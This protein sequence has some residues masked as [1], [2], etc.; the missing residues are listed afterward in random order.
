[1]GRQWIPLA[2]LGFAELVLV[3]AELFHR[4]AVTAELTARLPPATAGYVGL[5]GLTIDGYGTKAR[6][7]S[8][9]D[10]VVA[11][12]G[13]AGPAWQYALI[14]AFL[15]VVISYAVAGGLRARTVVMSIVGVVLAVPVLD[16]LLFS[17]FGLDAATRGPLLAT[18]GLALVAWYERS[19][20]VLAVAVAAGAVA[21]VIADLPGALISATV[22]V[23]GAFAAT[24]P[25]WG[26]DGVSGSRW[27]R[28]GSPSS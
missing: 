16:L 12:T 23:A 7:L 27:P 3:T 24:L 26:R 2:L 20:L 11:Y 18:L 19:P 21:V 17:R 22:L 13:G 6:F 28:R 9:D 14:A 15:A 25:R 1:M 10:T 4:S 5:F 8:L